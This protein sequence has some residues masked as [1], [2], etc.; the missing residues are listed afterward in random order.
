MAFALIGTGIYM[1]CD[2]ILWNS[3]TCTYSQILSIFSTRLQKV[4]NE[5]EEI[6]GAKEARIYAFCHFWSSDPCAILNH[7]GL[8][9]S[10][11]FI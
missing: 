3:V 8:V 4:I 5:S 7:E 10:F 2:N 9:N 1:Y 6:G 11:D